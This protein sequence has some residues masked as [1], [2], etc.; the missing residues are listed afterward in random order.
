VLAI[1]EDARKLVRS[2]SKRSRG[3]FRGNAL[4]QLLVCLSLLAVFPTRDAFAAR[5]GATIFHEQCAT[6]HEGGVPRAPTPA[7]LK[8]F[9]PERVVK[10]LFDGVMAAQGR[11]L[12]ATEARAVAVY[13]TGKPFT[14]GALPAKA[15]CADKTASFDKVKEFWNGWGGDATNQRFQSAAL[16]GLSAADV[17][18]LKLKWAFAI[19][20]VIRA[21]G[22]PTVV[23]GTAFIGT[24]ADKV[25]ALDAK[26]G[27][28]RWAFDADAG[29]RTAI[30]VGR[31]ADGWV[32]YFGDLRGQ[33]YA[34]DAATGKQIWKMRADDH[35]FAYI[36][37]GVTLHDGR[38]YVGV[39]SREET[40]VTPDYPCCNFRGSVSALDAKT[41][42]VIWKSY[43]IPDV[44]KPTVD[45]G[46][47]KMLWGPAGGS[48]WS[49]PT[50]DPVKRAVYVGTGNDYTGP[51]PKT[52]D[53]IMAFDMGDGHV[54]WV[55]QMTRDDI[56][57]VPCASTDPFKC[58]HGPDYD[59]GSSPILITLADGK[60]V[61]S[62][63]QKSG[64]VHGVDPDQDGKILWQVRIGKGGYEGGV[65]FGIGS[66]GQ[67]IYAPLSD[68]RFKIAQAGE[69]GGRPTIMG[70][71]ATLDP[72]S[73]G[74][75]FALDPA[76]GKQIWHAPPPDCHGNTA[77]S[78]AQSSAP[79]AI[80]GIVFSGSVDGHMRAYST[81]D[82]RIVWD[83]DTNKTYDAVD[84]IEAHG[85]SIDGPGAV[86]VDGVVYTN[87]GYGYVGEATGNVLLAFTVD[88]K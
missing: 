14:G 72:E 47:G 22:Q 71:P 37:G 57:F 83:V 56:G 75:L 65:E 45:N 7:A 13:V 85:G 29:V 35:Q 60:R 32:T 4:K 79:T 12:T 58:K 82:G 43:T 49:A 9:E 38:L 1:A 39:A 59:F 34:V 76:T 63:G 41:G 69:A 84:G 73:G 51:E 68:F 11:A 21:Y 25:Y 42:K 17:P 64:I 80:P 81:D 6:C 78:P 70:V 50:I 23:G 19:P 27:C 87:S 3:A 26:T 74:G 2:K 8:S 10:A 15:F 54:R 53:A 28:I 31:V 20:G 30:A 33:V 77:C 5:D 24:A 61:L 52:T 67:K 88:G 66:D 16:A 36:T 40:A 18:K 86:I 44:A 48:V 46:Q 62:A 55:Q